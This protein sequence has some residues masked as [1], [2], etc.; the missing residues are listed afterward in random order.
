MFAYRWLDRD[1][2]ACR[3]GQ[4]LSSAVPVAADGVAGM[5]Q[6]AKFNNQPERFSAQLKEVPPFVQS[7]RVQNRMKTQLI[8]NLTNQL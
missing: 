5:T 8:T 4:G 1:T 6:V 7:Q 2:G 3:K